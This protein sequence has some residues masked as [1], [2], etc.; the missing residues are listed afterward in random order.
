[1]PDSTRE[2]L[3]KAMLFAFGAA[4]STAEG[5]KSLAGDMVN[6]GEMTR[7]DADRLIADLMDRGKQAQSQ[8][9]ERIGKAVT[10][11]LKNAGLPSREEFD[12]L[13]ARVRKLEPART[14]T[15]AKP[16]P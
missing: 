4:Y 6:R 11:Y 14:R 1:M 2:S 8:V 12:Q 15:K 9:N 13:A 16:T 7:T 3:R 5:I 10:D